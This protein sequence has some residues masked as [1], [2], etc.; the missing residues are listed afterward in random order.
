MASR[1]LGTLTWKLLADIGGFQQSLSTA[2]KAVASTGAAADAASG[3]IGAMEKKFSLLSSAAS[4]LGK[5]L[6]DAFSVKALYSAVEGYSVLTNRL[7]LVTSG[8]AELAAAQQAV[9]TIA[10]ASAQ[11]LATTAALYQRIAANQDSLKLS[12]EGVVG[13]AGTISKTFALSGASAQTAS[14]ALAVLGQAFDTGVLKGDALNTLMGQVP[15][16]GEAIAQGMGKTVGELTLMGAAGE[17]SA[18][19]VVNAL[20]SQAGAVEALYSKTSSTLGESLTKAENSLTHFVGELD[21]A[22]GGSAQL[23]SFVDG[24][25]GAVDG[26]LPGVLDTVKEN[27]DALSQ[28]LTTGLYVALGRVA[29]GYAALVPVAVARVQVASE[30][31]KASLTAASAATRKAEVDLVSA[32]NAIEL[33]RMNQRLASTTLEVVAADRALA[34]AKANALLMSERVGAAR[35]AEA[36]ANDMVARTS[37]ASGIATSVL[38]RSLQA[39]AGAGRAV[40]GMMGGPV[41]LAFMVGATALSFIDFRSSSEKAREGLQDLTGPMDQIIARF[42]AMTTEQQ[43]GALVR[44]GEAQAEAVKAA[45]EEFGSLQASLKRGMLGSDSLALPSRIAGS[46]GSSKEFNDR[47][48]IWETY[49]D[50][51]DKAKGS[52]QAIAPILEELSRVPGISPKLIDELKKYAESW[53]TENETAKQSA[54]RQKTLQDQ[55]AKNAAETANGTTKTE[56]MTDAG[57][58][59]LKT[60]DDQLAKLQDNNDVVKEANRYIAEHKELS[61]ADKAAILSNA[62]ARKAQAAA[63]EAAAS[64]TKGLSNEMTSMKSAFQSA[65]EDYQRQIDLIDETTQKRKFYTEAEKLAL[66][67]AN[68]KYGKL[69]ENQRKRLEG[70]AAELDGKKALVKADEDAKKLATLKSGLDGDNQTAKEGFERELFGAGH[71]EKYSER[72]KEILSIRQDFGKKLA[73]MNEEYQEQKLAEDPGAEDRFK[74]ETE[75]LSGALAERLDA[76]LEYYGAVDELQTNWMDG[77]SEAWENFAVQAQDYSAQAADFVTGTLGSATDELGGAINDVATGTKSLGE[78]TTDMIAGF[79]KTMIATLADMAAQWLVYQA[80]QMLVGKTVQ[81]SAGLGLV[82]NAQATSFQAQLAAYASTAAIPVVGPAAAP[83]AAFAAAA[84]TAPMVAG[85]ASAAMMGMAHDGIDTIP[86]EGTWLLDGGERVLSPNQNRDLTR[87]LSS[88]NDSGFG[89]GGLTINAPVT[90]QAQPGMSDEAARRQGEMMGEGL[91]QTIR[92]VVNEEFRQGGTMWRR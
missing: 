24:F 68:G 92:Q 34:A 63:N 69:D 61:E 83:A 51:L 52:T 8:S 80:V 18:Q 37:T 86:R 62:H 27:S 13:V 22:T 17:L 19:S 30:E 5:P 67:I 23:A 74:A 60:L 54:E 44:W 14:S 39:T 50:R 64:S 82:A 42:K 38:G 72:M 58:A 53:S 47:V 91:K 45:N 79:A 29:G 77:V 70:M 16:L 81:S 15:A 87:Y 10:Q 57:R 25:A 41:G 28:A 46:G 35:A 90:V 2:S 49:R 3:Q 88:A 43:A 78:A 85:V 12:G 6:A 9:F 66:D 56:G 84:A 4:Q 48:K 36:A 21:Q 76:Q 40:L 31:A 73:A 20:V 59:Y 65:E 32:K 71:G 26:S 7:K 55:L 33:A 89:T 11:P 1:S 75:L